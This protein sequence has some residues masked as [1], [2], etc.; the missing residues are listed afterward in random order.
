MP[1]CSTCGAENRKHASV[2]RMC[3]R[4]LTQED[5]TVPRHAEAPQGNRTTMVSPLNRMEAAAAANLVS[6]SKCGELISIASQYC[7]RC[8]TAMGSDKTVTMVSAKSTARPRLVLVLEDDEIGDEYPLECDTV[9][10]RKTGDVTF[11][12]DDFMSGRHARISKRGNGFFLTDEGSRN[13][14]FVKIDGEVE[15]KPGDMV[16]VG[17]QLFRFE[18]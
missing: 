18:V 2:C 10:G 14:T 11:P 8:G 7:H 6:C 12:H 5:R 1:I 9:I 16:L 17:K 3:S 4:P 13:G 15:L